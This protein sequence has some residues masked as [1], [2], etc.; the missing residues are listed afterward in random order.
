VPVWDEPDP[1]VVAAQGEYPLVRAHPDLEPS[2]RIAVQD[3][4]RARIDRVGRALTSIG[5]VQARTIDR[6]LRLGRIG[7]LPDHHRRAFE[8]ARTRAA[9]GARRRL[10]PTRALLPCS[11]PGARG[12]AGA[13]R[14]FA[15]V[16][17]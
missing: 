8:P 14:I 3:A 15:R 1:A 5:E 16:F 2:H 17:V 11:R 6:E 9:L 4:Q 12:D 10:V 13:G 7:G